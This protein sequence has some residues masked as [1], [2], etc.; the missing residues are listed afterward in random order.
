MKYTIILTACPNKASAKKIAQRL[1]RKKLAACV[2]ISAPVESHFSWKNKISKTKEVIL[3][4]KS[5]NA[6]F[7]RIND[8]IKDIHPY[9]VPEI[10]SISIE[11]GSRAYLQWIDEVT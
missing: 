9:E 6:L 1:L 5:R 2:Q 4:I 8:E 3:S 10:L 7:S 11:R